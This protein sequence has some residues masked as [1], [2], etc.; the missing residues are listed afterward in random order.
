MKEEFE[1]WP[2]KWQFKVRFSQNPIYTTFFKSIG[3]TVPRA[4]D[5]ASK[6]RSP[7]HSG[8]YARAVDGGN[9]SE[10]RT[11]RG[12]VLGALRKHVITAA[13]IFR[14]TTNLMA[15]ITVLQ[16]KLNCF[17]EQPWTTKQKK[18]ANIANCYGSSSSLNVLRRHMVY[19]YSRKLSCRQL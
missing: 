15:S 4:D 16:R 19:N 2:Q 3:K 13:N 7:K 17:Y 14:M 6:T 11:R 5:N 18:A 8:T 1:D 10:L 9:E 12:D